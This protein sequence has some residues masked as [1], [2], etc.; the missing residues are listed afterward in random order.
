V[1][2]HNDHTLRRP[3]GS[4]DLVELFNGG[5]TTIDLAGLGMTDDPANPFKF[6]FPAGARLAPSEYLVLLAAEPDAARI[7]A[8]ALA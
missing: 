8:W 7:C 2:A 6:V 5:G 1:L 4:P 3:G